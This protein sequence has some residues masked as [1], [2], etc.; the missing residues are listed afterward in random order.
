MFVQIL[1]NGKEKR[2]LKQHR[3]ENKRKEKRNPL[4]ENLL[5]V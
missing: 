5:S 2:K 1:K 3:E 4:K